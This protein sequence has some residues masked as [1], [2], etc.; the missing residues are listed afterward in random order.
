[1]SKLHYFLKKQCWLSV[2]IG[3]NANADC[4]SGSSTSGQYGSGSRVLMTKNCKIL[5][6]KI[7]FLFF[8][9]RPPNRTSKLQ[10]KPSAPKRE[11]PALEK[12]E[13][14]I[15]SLFP[16]F[17]VHFYPPGSGSDSRRQKS[18]RI[19]IHNAEKKV[20]EILA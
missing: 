3:S 9:F 1:M 10:E 13:I 14:Q 12:H 8:F 18:M 6:R 4:G 5:Q 11:H 20:K 19:R 15:S 2:R 17:A 7:F 16:I